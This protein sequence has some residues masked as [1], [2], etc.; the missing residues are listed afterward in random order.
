MCF[1]V[2]P[3]HDMPNQTSDFRLYTHSWPGES[4][5][6]RLDPMNFCA[7][8]PRR[9]HHGGLPRGPSGRPPRARRT[10]KRPSNPVLVLQPLPFTRWTR[11]TV[12]PRLQGTPWPRGAGPPAAPGPRQEAPIVGVFGYPQGFARSTQRPRR[13]MGSGEPAA[14]P[15][16]PPG[17]SPLHAAFPWGLPAPLWATSHPAG[18]TA[19]FSPSGRGPVDPGQGG[20]GP[21]P[22]TPPKDAA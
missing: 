12:P 6:R 4:S 19:A 16:A 9:G 7:P 1:N 10:A 17:D 21:R 22:P 3:Q 15:R 11:P 8:G 2:G 5:T 18:P 14:V 20:P 13:G